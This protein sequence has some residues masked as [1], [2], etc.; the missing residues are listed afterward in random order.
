MACTLNEEKEN[1]IIYVKRNTYKV[2]VGMPEKTPI[3]IFKYQ[4][5]DNLKMDFM[6]KGWGGMEWTRLVQDREQWLA[7]VNTI[8]NI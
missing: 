7:L 4:W 6:R 1:D 3:G 5:E 2:L 8:M